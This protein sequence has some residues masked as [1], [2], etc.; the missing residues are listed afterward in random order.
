MAQKHEENE[1]FEIPGINTEYGIA[2]TGGTVAGYRK[3]L[4]T[5]YRDT[6]ERLVFFNDY[7]KDEHPDEKK[8]HLLTVYAHSLKSALSYIGVQG[9]SDKAKELELAGKAENTD[10][11]SENLAEFT[12]KL[13]ELMDNIDIAVNTE[14]ESEDEGDTI[15][16]EC[17]S[18]LQELA[19]LIKSRAAFSKIDN[20]IEELGKMPLKNRLKNM[21]DQVSDEVLMAEY[22][23]AL[24]MLQKIL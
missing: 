23:N 16:P 2:S 19:D 12:E 11:I 3:V 22:D 17:V 14:P 15:P 1:V 8:V 4:Y 6:Q 24:Q 9:L 20:T 5:L 18:K 10:F 13:T 21:L 7:L